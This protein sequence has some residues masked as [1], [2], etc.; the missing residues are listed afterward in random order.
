[1]NRVNLFSFRVSKEERQAIA[2]L[3]ILLQRSQSDAVR[4]VVI[5]AVRELDKQPANLPD[6][7]GFNIHQA[8]NAAT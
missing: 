3:A 1:M 5:Q 8:E 7:V 4:F 2:K 6:F